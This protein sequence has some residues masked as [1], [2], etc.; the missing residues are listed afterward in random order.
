V[1][2][3]GIIVHRIGRNSIANFRLT[4]SELA[5]L[6][7]G[8]SVLFGGGAQQAANQVRSTFADSDRFSELHLLAELVA[9]TTAGH[10]R[11]IGF[12]VIAVPTKRLPNHGRIVHPRGIDGFDDQS[13]K[14][15]GESFQVTAIPRE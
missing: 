6:P 9:T 2:D 4:D 14:W 8:V 5:L 11:A 7:P 13:L 3:D 12:D 1:V 15:L 10:V